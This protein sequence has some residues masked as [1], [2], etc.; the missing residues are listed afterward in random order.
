MILIDL[1][2]AFDTINYE[3]LLRKMCYLG[4]SD[5]TILWFKSYLTDRTFFVN[6]ENTFSEASVLECGVPQGSIL[7]PILFLLYVND[8]PQAVSKC[9]IL[10]YADDTCLVF[11]DKCVSTIES[12][13]S[14][15]FNS[16]CDWFED[17]KL[18]IHLG[19]DKTKC[20]LF[21]RRRKKEN[22]SIKRGNISIKQHSKVTY[23]GCLLDEDHSGESMANKVLGK[24]NGRLKFLYRKNEYLTKSLRR[25]LC[26]ALIQPHFDFASVAWYPLL[27]KRLLKKV[28]VA[29]N[30]C[31]RFCL[32]SNSRKHVGYEEYDQINWLPVELRFHQSVCT[33]VH[34][35]FNDKAPGYMA[36]I[37]LRDDAKRTRNSILHLKKP[38]AKTNGQKSLSFIGPSIWNQL[39]SEIK[40]LTNN[41]TF[42]HQVKSLFLGK[43]KEKENDI[44]LRN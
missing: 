41:N 27:S 40:I 24:I 7:G 31:I 35:F 19:E 9:D 29:Q 8:M 22:L 16:L 25:L 6:L 4:F 10:L 2:K 39:P 11:S 12:H 15:D 37:F 21:S 38:L 13:L 36:D 28:T 33:S 3:I 14:D 1:Q 34:N 23:L 5:N 17:N 18:S 20:I 26:N 42:K 44:Y 30:K 32:Q 43:L